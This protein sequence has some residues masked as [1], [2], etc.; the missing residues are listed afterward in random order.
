MM[1]GQPSIKIIKYGLLVRMV[2]KSTSGY[3][4]NL[5]IYAGEGKNYRKLL[6]VWDSH[7]KHSCIVAE[8]PTF[9]DL[10]V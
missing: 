4:L 7:N 3:I 9:I 6:K 1:H 5:E 8:W 2:T 10:L